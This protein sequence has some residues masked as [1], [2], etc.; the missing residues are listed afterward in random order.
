MSMKTGL[1]RPDESA[2]FFTDERCHI[3]ELSGGADDPALSIARARVEPGVTTQLHVLD[4]AERYVVVSG[5]GEMEVGGDVAPVGPGDVVLIPAGTPQR[6]ANTGEADL[7]FYCLCT[8]AW[9]PD[10]YR[11]LE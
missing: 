6:I 5:R 7:V 4:I 11:A 8:P 2:E 1:R 10:T 9:T 3:L